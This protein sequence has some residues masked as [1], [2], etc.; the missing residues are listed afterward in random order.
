VI[1]CGAIAREL[2]RIRDLNDWT[3]VEIQCLPAHLHGCPGK[4]PDA[5]CAVIEAQRDRYARLFVGYAD[6]GTAGALD[7][8]LAAGGVNRIPGAHCYEFFAGGATFG[9]LATEEPGSF[10]LTDFLVRH[11]ER[12]VVHGLGLDRHPQLLGTYFGNYRRLVYIAQTNQ[13]DL[14]RL[15]RRHAA[16]L[17]LEYHYRLCGD[18][19]LAAALQPFLAPEDAC[20]N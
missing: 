10:F 11:F 16:F 2:V 6:C 9:E 15:A 14:Q 3:R 7:R 12:L 13:P 20:R 18:V 17:G 1:T 19:P 5:V 8:A 4:I